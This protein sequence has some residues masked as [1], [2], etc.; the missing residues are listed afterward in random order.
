MVCARVCGLAR[1]H[2]QCEVALL[3]AG[4][5]GPTF[6]TLF[7]GRWLSQLFLI[8]PDSQNVTTL[9]QKLRQSC[10]HD[11]ATFVSQLADEIERAPDNAIHA[12]FKQLVWPRKFV[13]VQN[14]PLPRLNKK[15]GTFCK[16]A[17]EIT[18]RWR[19]HFANFGQGRWCSRRLLLSNVCR[20]KV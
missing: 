10:R 4:K 15:D 1:L 6:A 19:R 16:S 8:A 11:K 2:C 20:C 17:E 13:A 7:G 18:E 12:A 9:G 5:Q 3:T 14:R